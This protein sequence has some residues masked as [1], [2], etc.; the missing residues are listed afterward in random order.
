[1][2]VTTRP[3]TTHSYEERAMSEFHSTNPSTKEEM[4]IE[5][6]RLGDLSLTPQGTVLRHGK[7]ANG[8]FYPYTEPRR[9]DY[10]IPIG[11]FQFKITF[12]GK[13]FNVSVH[14]TI[15]IAANGAIPDGLEVDHIDEDKSNNTLGNLQL[16]THQEN[17]T[18]SAYKSRGELSTRAIFSS[19]DVIE[20][21]RRH[22]EGEPL[23][24]ISK[25]FNTSPQAINT[26]VKRRSW[27]HLP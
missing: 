4:A 21:R 6:V 17:A 3:N 26:I 5:L 10:A 18:R 25:S 14:R 16:K 23:R 11:Y 13:P 27:R 8:K 19:A 20:M 24:S 1:M 2:A 12:G 9:I 22:A 7:R 15:W